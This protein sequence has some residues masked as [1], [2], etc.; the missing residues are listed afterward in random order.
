MLVMT[1]VTYYEKLLCCG[2]IVN[3]HDMY[4]LTYIV[5]HLAVK[6]R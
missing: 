6:E 2:Y 5:L 4:E 1:K 3:F